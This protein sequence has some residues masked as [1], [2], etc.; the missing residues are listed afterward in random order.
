MALYDFQREDAERFAR[1]QGA[2]VRTRGDELEF[3]RCPYCNGGGKDKFT[4]SI[5]LK[6]GAFK[7][8]R[9]SCGAHGNMITLHKDF[10]FSVLTSTWA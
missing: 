1:E 6:T 2:R 3:Q 10:N 9:A 5:N 4:F 7:C 8:L